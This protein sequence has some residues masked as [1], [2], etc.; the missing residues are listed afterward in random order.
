MSETK[1]REIIII[2]AGVVGLATALQLAA[3]GRDIA[4]LDPNE[5]G[6]GA[7]YGNAGTI[8]NYA[9]MPVGTPS[10]LKN[11]PR[12]LIDRDSP[13]AIR[14]TAIPALM[15]W[16]LRFA[17]QSLPGNAARNAAVIAALLADS[18]SAWRNLATEIGAEDLLR[19]NGCLYLY[20][21][22]ATLAGAA[23]DIAVRKR[24]GIAQETLSPE[25]VRR[26]EPALPLFEGG[27]VLFPDAVN[28]TD[29]AAMMRRLTEAVKAAGVEIIRTEATAI[30]RETGGVHVSCA[31]G[32]RRRARCIIVAAGAYSRRFAA[33]AG[34][35]VPLDTER[36]YH[37]E[38]DIETPPLSRPVCPTSR[39]FYLVPM[40]G[41]LRVAGTVEL[42][43]LAAPLNPRRIALLERGAKAIFPDLGKPDRQWLGFRPSMPDS[44]PVIGAS[45]HGNDV[46]YAFGHGHL[47]LT[48]AP[49]TANL[50]E[51]ILAGQ[52]PSGL[53]AGTSPRR[54]H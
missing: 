18:L 13:L 24:F 25:D 46:I 43:G 41:R 51:R 36:G 19:Q 39:G 2:G 52:S 33:Q 44:I 45:K 12:L 40:A 53:Q 48:L 22:P 21:N 20:D 26:L 34:D 10:V 17:W 35:P 3:N 7:S 38:Y 11:L 50:V 29:P 15:P 27:G 4:I 5:L 14:R 9:V 42:G 6:S 16:L 54:F 30:A 8:A 49:V 32:R 31:D 47:G 1:Q 23:G 28:L 37:V